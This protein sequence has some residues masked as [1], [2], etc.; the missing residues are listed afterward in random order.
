VSVFLWHS[1]VQQNRPSQCAETLEYLTALKSIKI[2]NYLKLES[3]VVRLSV[4]VTIC[5]LP[6]SRSVSGGVRLWDHLSSGRGG[7]HACGKMFITTVTIG[8]AQK[9]CKEGNNKINVFSWETNAIPVH[10]AVVT[11]EIK[12]FQNYFS[13]QW[14]PTE[15]I[16]FQHAE[17]CTKLFQKIIAAQEYFPTSSMSLK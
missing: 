16:L 12:L 7:R 1:V 2:I 9:A 11:C 10:Y 14:H 15:I 5:P 4:T 3:H 17:T 13:L 8:T 6:L